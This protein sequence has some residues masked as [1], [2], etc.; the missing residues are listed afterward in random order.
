M[1]RILMLI[2]VAAMLMAS[3]TKP[4]L[5]AESK[6]EPKYTDEARDA[7]IQGAVVMEIFIDA[8]GHVTD[9]RVLKPLGYGL[10]EKAIEAV[11]A[12]RFNPATKN[13]KPV[14]IKATAEIN[15]RLLDD[16]PSEKKKKDQ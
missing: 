12:W 3:D 2:A 9:T 16:P 7:N 1:L 10:D 4:A 8:E 5:I 11:S 13:G 6:V 14:A 15:F